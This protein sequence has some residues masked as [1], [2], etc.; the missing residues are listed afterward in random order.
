MISLITSGPIPSTRSSCNHSYGRSDGRG[1]F[2]LGNMPGGALQYLG[3]YYTVTGIAPT[4]GKITAGAE[5]DA[6]QDTA[7]YSSTAMW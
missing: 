3:L 4:T 7:I 6:A 5:V 1:R 2:P